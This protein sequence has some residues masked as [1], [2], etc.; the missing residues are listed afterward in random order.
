MPVMKRGVSCGPAE[1][2]TNGHEE[3]AMQRGKDAF[4]GLLVFLACWPTLG[5]LNSGP[6][7]I[8]SQERTPPARPAPPALAQNGSSDL[9]IPGPAPSS[10]PQPPPAQPSQPVQQ[11]A[12]VTTPPQSDPMTAL[13]NLQKEAAERYAQ[14]DSYIARLRR[15]EQIG[16]KDQPEELMVVK[17]R[18]EPWSVH[19]KWIGEEAK[20]REVVF[21]KGRYGDKLH[22]RLAAGD[23]PFMPAGK[24]MEFDPNSPLVRSSSR[25]PITQAG[26]G[27]LIERFSLV[28][29]A[30]ER[31]DTSRG[32]LQYHG[33]IQRPEFSQLCEAVEQ[34]VPPGRDPAMPRGGKRWWF[35]DPVTRFP[36]LVVTLD[37]TGHQVEYYCYDLFK[38]GVRLD[39][40]DFNPERLWGR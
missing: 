38:L 30:L 33:R 8:A 19:M 26:V 17:F 37:H 20:G 18:K 22:T 5:C 21:V 35:F 15:R 32:T 25:H 10:T 23:V 13:R 11:V 6:R 27:N 14:I 12:A 24:R 40:A 7:R 39:D 36:T 1:P 31:G 3:R 2:E 4:T 28:V 34:T 16:G 9:R 29:A